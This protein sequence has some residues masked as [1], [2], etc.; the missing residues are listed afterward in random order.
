MAKL[1]EPRTLAGFR[2]FLPEEMA[3]R[4][5]VM[6]I[7][8]RVFETYG[9]SE[10]QTPALEYQDILL[11]KYGEEAEKLMYLFEDQG[12]RAIGLRYDLT[13]PTARVVAQYPNL[14]KP[15]KRYQIQQVYRADK[16]QKGRYREVTQCD[17]DTFGT[18]S[19]LADAEIIAVIYESLLALGFKS[20]TIRLNSRQ[21]LF[22]LMRKAGVSEERYL[23]MIQTIDK[24]DK[25]TRT[26]V[27]K[28]LE[29]KGLSK[30]QATD[31]FRSIE[32]AVPDDNLKTV[33]D[34]ARQLG[35]PNEIIKFDPVLS[36][37]LDYYSGSIFETVVTEPKIGSITG[38]GRYDQLIGQFTGQNVPAVGT[39]L[40]LDRIAD[41]ISELKLWPE[42]EK[43]KTKVLVTIFSPNLLNN[44]LR[45]L[46][47]LRNLGI[48]T[49]IYLDQTT[50]LDKQLKYADQK[51]IPYAV[52][53]GPE[54]AE[55]NLVTV[56]NLRTKEQ[57]TI[58]A[59]NVLDEI[60]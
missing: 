7:L 60:K 56:K 51:G 28:E 39:T 14:A 38:G 32:D 6:E 49:E 12:K 43:T 17:I 41:V 9:F 2:D 26:D 25:K 45:I 37:G 27:E 30:D 36:R 1:I 33:M 29:D 44:S 47:D 50:K 59:E 5:K 35:V 34:F 23:T 57:K 13:V 8:R 3:V 52:I 22:D 40:G 20:F 19:P 10:M 46:N 58:P 42:M 11:G 16:P 4:R 55:K 48:P 53:L 31:I 15:F 54:E 18:T 24:L 21:V